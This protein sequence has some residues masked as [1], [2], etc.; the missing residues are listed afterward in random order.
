L[1]SV[2]FS[3]RSGLCQSDSAICI[4]SDLDGKSVAAVAAL[5]VLLSGVSATTRRTS[6]VV[7]VSL[8]ALLS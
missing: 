6:M 1:S 7:A 2:S 5:N 3:A 8:A 4:S